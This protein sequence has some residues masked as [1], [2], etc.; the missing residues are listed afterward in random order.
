MSG[1]L[2]AAWLF[3]FSH[4]LCNPGGRS[5]FGIDKN[6]AQQWLSRT[7][8]GVEQAT[9]DNLSPVLMTSNGLAINR[10]INIV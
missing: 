9:G 3:R 7:Q 1:N 8:L 5:I 4:P 6:I 10:R 2:F